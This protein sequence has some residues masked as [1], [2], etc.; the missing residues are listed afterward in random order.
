MLAIRA[1][2]TVYGAERADAVRHQ[3]RAQTIQPRIAICGIGRVQLTAI[4]DPFQHTR[5]LEL[6]QQLEIVVARDAEQVTHAGFLETAK[7]EVADIH[8]LAYGAG[9]GFSSCIDQVV[10]PRMAIAAQSPRAPTA[11][12]VTDS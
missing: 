3:K 11:C 1:A 7:Q 10:R 5:V 2:N 4:A 12:P 6:L 9:H 8:S